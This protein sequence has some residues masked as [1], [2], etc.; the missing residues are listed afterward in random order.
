MP[1]FPDLNERRAARK[2]R[3][4]STARHQLMRTRSRASGRLYRLRCGPSVSREIG[5][6]PGE[7]DTGPGPYVEYA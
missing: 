2:G 3:R 1:G 5:R 7:I 4:A 6:M